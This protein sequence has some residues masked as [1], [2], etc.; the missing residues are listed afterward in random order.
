MKIYIFS[1]LSLLSIGILHAQDIYQEQVPSIVLN[2]FTADFEGAKDIEWERNNAHY[3]VEFE[4]GWGNDHE[5]WYTAGGDV[6][7]H[8]EDYSVMDLPDTVRERL[9]D[10]F[11]GYSID[12]L[13][14]ITKKDQVVYE[15]ELNSF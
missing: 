14:K 5:I 6:V 12:D 8:E 11:K 3:V 7:L 9:N 13:V 1:I 2:N 10:D 4:M 15:M